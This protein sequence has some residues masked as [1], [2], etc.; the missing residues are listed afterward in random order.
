MLRISR[1]QTEPFYAL[2]YLTAGL[3]GKPMRTQLP[4][5]WAEA[6]GLPSGINALVLT[7]DLQGREVGPKNRL[8]G[9]ALADALDSLQIDG[10]IPKPD[11]TVVC[12]DLF[13]RPDCH[14]RGGTGPIDD[15]FFALG[16]VCEQVVGVLGNHDEL[17]WPDTAM[18]SNIAILDGTQKV[19]QGLRVAGLS[20]I[21]GDPK[22]NLR[23]PE[24]D[25]L[26]QLGSLTASS[27]NLLLLHQGPDDPETSRR[28]NASVRRVLETGYAGVTIFGHTRWSGSPL[29]RLGNGQA[30]NVNSRV[31][32]IISG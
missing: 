28:G 29:I 13:E 18:K 7:S 4:F 32:V 30:L 25:F 17:A 23:R 10:I 9:C 11:V 1:I 21:I 2:P 15:V 14:K 26:K 27:P 5:F 31:I 16:G 19:C 3:K 12:G 8:L 22:R 24:H 6:E 20:G